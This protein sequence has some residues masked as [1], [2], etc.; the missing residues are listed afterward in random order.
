LSDSL[1]FTSREDGATLTF[2]T[3]GSIVAVATGPGY[4]IAAPFST[5][6]CPP[7]TEFLERLG[8]PPQTGRTE[9]S[10]STLEGELKFD[11]VLDVLGHVFLTYHLRSPDIGS[12]AWW[13]FTGRL[14]LEMG[15]IEQLYKRAQA[16]WTGAT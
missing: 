12:A 4:E 9:L 11:A 1:T 15:E 6:M 8:R 10:W 2:K 5:F 3:G 14:V 13:S 7:L 16:I